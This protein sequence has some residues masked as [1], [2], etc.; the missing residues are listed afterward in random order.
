M[1]AMFVGRL[2]ALT[3]VLMI[4]GDE[5]PETVRYPKEEVLVG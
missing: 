5:E 2:G 3:M 1:L 4:A